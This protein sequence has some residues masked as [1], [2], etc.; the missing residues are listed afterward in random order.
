MSRSESVSARER[1]RVGSPAEGPVPGA[2]WSDHRLLDLV[3]LARP[4]LVLLIVITFLGY[5][6]TG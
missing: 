1:P 5:A 2:F 4:A 3:P 6:I